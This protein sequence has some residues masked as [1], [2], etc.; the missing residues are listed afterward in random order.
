MPARVKRGSI[1]STKI[2]AAVKIVVKSV[3]GKAFGDDNVS[4]WASILSELRRVHKRTDL[5]K[6][7]EKRQEQEK[8][9]TLNPTRESQK[10]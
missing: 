1:T 7:V 5:E 4:C 2:T 3:G 8:V 9:R 6:N 10:G